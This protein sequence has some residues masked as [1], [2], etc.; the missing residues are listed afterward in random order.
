MDYI[1]KKKSD[2]LK[3]RYECSRDAKKRSGKGGFPKGGTK[4]RGML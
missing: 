4:V 2:K 1:D 3:E